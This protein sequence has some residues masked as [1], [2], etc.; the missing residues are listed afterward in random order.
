MGKSSPSGLYQPCWE[1]GFS[2]C[3]GKHQFLCI[4]NGM[5]SSHLFSKDNS[6]PLWLLSWSQEMNF[7]LI[8]GFVSWSASKMVVK[9]ESR[10]LIMASVCTIQ[11]DGKHSRCTSSACFLVPSLSIVIF[12]QIPGNRAPHWSQRGFY[13]FHVLGHFTDSSPR[14]KG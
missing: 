6:P 8:V 12:N 13:D 14:K 10:N 4:A 3:H 9:V 5:D 11:S 2:L 7:F 1:V